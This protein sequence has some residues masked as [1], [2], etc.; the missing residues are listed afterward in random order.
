LGGDYQGVGR[1]Q[2]WR[3]CG[4]RWHRRRSGD[5]KR[6]EQREIAAREERR[7]GEGVKP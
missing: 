5:A 7:K 2:S 4:W 3:R 1:R 6:R